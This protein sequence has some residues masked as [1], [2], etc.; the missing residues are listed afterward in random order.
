ML[1]KG[2]LL[3]CRCSN[4]GILLYEDKSICV[5]WTLVCTKRMGFYFAISSCRCGK[6]KKKELVQFAFIFH[7]LLQGR[8]IIKY[9][10]MQ[11]L[12]AFL[13]MLNY[14]PKHRGD[15]VGWKSWACHVFC[16]CWNLSMIWQSLCKL[17]M[18]SC[19]ITF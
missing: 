17:G 14:P 18:S 7:F 3:Y 16:L 10:Q 4:R 2:R 13:K 19:V 11:S 12:F 8:T 15:S 5:K 9:E 1:T 6:K